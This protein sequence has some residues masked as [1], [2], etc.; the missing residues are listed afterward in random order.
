MRILAR[1]SSSVK[2][3]RARLR[4]D[5]FDVDAVEQILERALLDRDDPFAFARPLGHAEGA[6]VEALVEETQAGVVGE[7]D[8]HRVPPAP[9]EDKESAAAHLATEPVGRKGAEPVEAPAQVDGVECDKDLDAVRDHRPPPNTSSPARNPPAS[10]P[11]RTPSRAAPTS[12]RIGVSTTASTDRDARTT[13]ARRT[14][15]A[16]PPTVPPPALPSRLAQSLRPPGLNSLPTQKAGAVCP[17][18]RHA[19]TLAVHF[20]SVSVIACDL[21]H[22]ETSEP[23]G[24]RRSGYRTSLTAP[25]EIPSDLAIRRDPW[26][27]SCSRRIASRVL[28]SSIVKLLL[29]VLEQSHHLAVRLHK[30][31]SDLFTLRRE[32]TPEVSPPGTEG[33]RIA[34][35]AGTQGPTR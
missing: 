7:E 30:D 3:T 24:G 20:D 28:S 33:T 23:R 19:A 21:G 31:V 15:F 22:E 10:N 11:R 1:G 4:C 14:P 2:P 35:I 8:L 27:F 25:R 34:G 32:Q 26:P 6:P 17:L 16:A 9:E 12:M 29:Q 13:R 5:R 18:A